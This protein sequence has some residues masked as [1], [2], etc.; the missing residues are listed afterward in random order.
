MKTIGEVLPLSSRF[1][2]DRKIDRPRRIVEDL[3]AALLRCKR[4]DLYMQFDR[5]LDDSE[6]ASLRDWLKRAAKNEP[7]EYIIGEVD[8]FGCAIKT[9][10]R[11]L[12]P[13]PETELLVERIANQV[14]DQKIIWDICTGS[15]CIGISLK[16]RFPSVEVY[17]SDLSS[18]ALSLAKENGK[19]NGVEVQFCQGDLFA[20][21]LGKKAD[22]IV[23]NPPYVST[24]EYLEID[25]SV[26]DFEPKQAL[27]GGES[28]LDFYERLAVELPGYLMPGGMAFLEIGAAQGNRVKEIFASPIWKRMELFPDLSGKDRFFFLEKQ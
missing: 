26:R 27:V 7:V 18:D 6:L 14:K 19:K 16:K 11:A 5:P 10:R 2:S 24:S 13:R 15:G 21:F 3:L 23:C 22:L 4:I 28:G 12:I 20:P 17:L 8:F 9:D 25:A 1:L